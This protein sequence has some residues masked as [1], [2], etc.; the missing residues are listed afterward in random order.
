MK[1]NHCQHGCLLFL[2]F[3]LIFTFFFNINKNE[4]GPIK[5]YKTI[6]AWI[7]KIGKEK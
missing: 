3:L 6:T 2:C 1:E 4:Y 5:Y 7:L